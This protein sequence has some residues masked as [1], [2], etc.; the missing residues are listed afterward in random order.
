MF[1]ASVLLFVSD[2]RKHYAPLHGHELGSN[3]SSFIYL[4]DKKP[5]KTTT[6]YV[7]FWGKYE[8][9]IECFRLKLL[10]SAIV[11]MIL[12]SVFAKSFNIGQK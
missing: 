3:V 8:E 1:I 5:P 9:S 11:T 12:K 4:A 2:F 6:F 10:P 7:N